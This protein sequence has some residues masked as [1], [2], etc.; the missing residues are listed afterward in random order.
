MIAVVPVRG[1]ELPAGARETVQAAGGIALVVG[2]DTA[3]ASRSL[4][5]TS[6]PALSRIAVA[7]LGSY[8]PARWAH[9]LAGVLSDEE[10]VVLP[11]SPDG[12]DLAPRL[13][14]VL[15]RPLIAGACR[16]SRSGAVVLRWGGSQ[17]VEI[18]VGTGRAY[19]ATFQAGS[20]SPPPMSSGLQRD[21]PELEV[22]T[23]AEL[24]G[25]SH[26]AESI[27]VL[28]ADPASVDLSEAPRII[29]GGGGL[30]GPG[31]FELLAEV[32]AALGASPG[33][34]RVVTDAGTL[35][36]ERQI[37]TTGV[38]VRPRVYV[39]LGISGAA[40]HV[41]GLGDP[42]H[43]ISVNL[44]P[45]CPMMAMADLAIVSDASDTLRALAK[46]L[47]EEH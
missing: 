31:D 44:D 43:V 45:S 47:A 36:H 3:R 41:A 11:A 37:G 22:V 23:A 20:A 26:D 1:G 6:E 17:L 34:T 27:A 35:G 18:A 2:E 40:Q 16:L 25:G 7:E 38:A 46:Q 21:A 29:A 4:N 39:A 42:A 5:E 14:C 10:V 28:E 8:A 30:A 9:Q 24:P 15:G 12:R 19:V 13:A 32:C 33:A